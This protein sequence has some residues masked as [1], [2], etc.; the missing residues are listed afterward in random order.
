MPQPMQTWTRLI[1]RILPSL[2][3]M[4]LAVPPQNPPRARRNPA[5]GGLNRL[6]PAS[7]RPGASKARTRVHNSCADCI[8]LHSLIISRPFLTYASMERS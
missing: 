7:L 2:P 4:S 5:R 8:S 1:W 3:G 6:N